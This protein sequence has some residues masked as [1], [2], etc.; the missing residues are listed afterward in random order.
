MCSKS[1]LL[2]GK[3]QLEQLLE[4]NS[5]VLFTGVLYNS[6]SSDTWSPSGTFDNII[7]YEVATS[8]LLVT[9]TIYVA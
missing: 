4:V 8:E 1:R 9:F 5:I 3:V 2:S 6:L 7:S